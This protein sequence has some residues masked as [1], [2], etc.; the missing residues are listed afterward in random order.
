VNMS[1]GHR[2]VGSLRHQRPRWT[3]GLCQQD[4]DQ[5]H[6]VSPLPP[7]QSAQ[8]DLFVPGVLRLVRIFHVEFKGYSLYL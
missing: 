2:L 6:L 1:V 5:L 3:D 7:V 8:D 4:S